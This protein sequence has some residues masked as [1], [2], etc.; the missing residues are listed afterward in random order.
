MVSKLIFW[1]EVEIVIEGKKNVHAK[2][3]KGFLNTKS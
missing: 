3:F 2:Q 1:V